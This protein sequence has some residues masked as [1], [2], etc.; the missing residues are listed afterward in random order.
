MNWKQD[1]TITQ[2]MGSE[3]YD[4]AD[5]ENLFSELGQDGY[6]ALSLGLIIDV[7]R[8]RLEEV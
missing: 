8:A 3:C 7:I 4:T 1:N 2:A 5:L 6:T